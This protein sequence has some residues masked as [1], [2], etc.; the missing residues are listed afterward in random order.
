MEK[1]E[2]MLRRALAWRSRR[3]PYWLMVDPQSDVTKTMGQESETGKVF[4]IGRDRFGRG[5][6][7]M[8]SSIQ[9][10]MD[11]DHHMRHLAYSIEAARA[12][13]VAGIDKIAVTMNLENYSFWS[14]VPVS[15][16]LETIEILCIVYPE[17]LGSCII[18]QC[19][20]IA[21][22]AFNFCKPFIDERTF[23]KFVF[24]SGSYAP[25]SECDMVMTDVIGPDWRRLT[26]LGLP[27]TQKAYSQYYGEEILG[28]CGFD[29]TA[30]WQ[31]R[32]RCDAEHAASA[33]GPPW[34]HLTHEV[35]LDASQW[36]GAFPGF[37]EANLG[38]AGSGGNSAEP[39]SDTTEVAT[40]LS[41]VVD[42]TDAGEDE[43]AWATRQP[44]LSQQ[45]II[46]NGA[47]SETASAAMK[48]A[49]PARIDAGAMFP[50]MLAEGHGATP[51]ADSVSLQTDSK[52]QHTAHVQASLIDGMGA[53][54]AI[55]LAV[56][57]LTCSVGEAKLHEHGAAPAPVDARSQYMNLP[58][59][60]G[61]GNDIGNI[62]PLKP[63]KRRSC[64]LGYTILALSVS[65]VVGPA[66]E[67]V[68]RAYRD[69]EPR[70][71][72]LE[73]LRTPLFLVVPL[74]GV[75]LGL[76]GASQ[77]HPRGLR[78]HFRGFRI[79]RKRHDSYS[80]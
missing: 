52:E 1:A 53:E 63:G 70:G 64:F 15:S 4:S 23:K 68:L 27:R 39:G 49:Q 69:V 28:A 51:A 34:K 48:I 44:A 7:M 60:F 32:L 61:L 10:T 73:R 19:P 67:S 8:D 80:V 56:A 45:N 31:S 50:S 3:M 6:C 74:A 42:L 36:D 47:T 35:A 57:P 12:E 11:Q 20:Q 24:L 78:L 66:V 65:L 75:G 77:P 29:F 79:F 25:N 2:A 37:W 38:M 54:A 16:V 72:L 5:L 58:D 13:C 30:Y 76:V 40:G 71:T 59:S 9:N 43:E 33:G 22:T 55:T 18:W 62:A 17:T 46:G 14:S 41:H 26:G 21:I